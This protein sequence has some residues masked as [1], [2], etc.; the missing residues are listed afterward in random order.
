MPWPSRS[1]AAM[2]FRICEVKLVSIA[3]QE[4]VVIFSEFVDLMAKKIDLG[5]EVIARVAIGTNTSLR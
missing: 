3:E 1:A 2:R 5:T 4:A